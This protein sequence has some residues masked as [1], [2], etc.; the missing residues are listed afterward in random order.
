MYIVIYVKIMMIYAYACDLDPLEL[1]R[2]KSM[3]RVG[4]GY[5]DRRNPS[6]GSPYRVGRH[7]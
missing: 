1:R 7:M 6:H 5:V 2:T 4:S 3:P